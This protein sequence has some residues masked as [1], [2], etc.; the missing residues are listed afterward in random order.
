MNCLLSDL[1]K[2]IGIVLNWHE[3]SMRNDKCIGQYILVGYLKREGRLTKYRPI[4][5]DNIKANFVEI[6]C[7]CVCGTIS[8]DS[9]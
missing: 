2:Y 1:T 4:W 9:E 6:R 3:S 8:S 7:V 5:E